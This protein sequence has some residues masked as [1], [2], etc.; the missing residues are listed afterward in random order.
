MWFRNGILTLLALNSLACMGQSSLSFKKVKL[1]ESDG[2][3]VLA[4]VDFLS[5]Q[6]LIAIRDAHQT[7]IDI[8]YDKIARMSYW[9]TEHSQTTKKIAAGI[10]TYGL[11]SLFVAPAVE[12]HLIINYGEQGSARQTELILND[13]DLETFVRIAHLET[14]KE[15]VIQGSAEPASAATPPAAGAPSPA[16]APAAAVSTPAPVQAPP[17]APPPPPNA[18]G[19]GTVTV[20]STPPGADILVNGAYSGSTPSTLKLDPGQYSISVEKQ[21]LAPWQRSVTVTDSSALILDAQL[22][23]TALPPSASVPPPAPPQAV[24]PAAV[25]APPGSASAAAPQPAGSAAPYLHPVKVGSQWGYVDPEG[26]FRY[27]PMADSAD[28]FAEGRALVGVIARH[29]TSS[30][31]F[32]GLDF[33]FAYKEY[34]YGWID[35]SGRILIPTQFSLGGTFS[36][37]LALAG[38]VTGSTRLSC[39]FPDGGIS[40]F[41]TPTPAD[42]AN[43]ATCTSDSKV[44]YVDISGNVALHTDFSDGQKFSEKLA[45]VAV[46]GAKPA[47]TRWG[48]IDHTGTLVIA[49]T[50]FQA[51]PF[52]EG[53]AGVKVKEGTKGKGEEWGF[54]DHTG[55][56]VVQPGYQF[57]ENFSEGM[58]AVEYPSGHGAG[59]VSREAHPLEKHWGYIDRSGAQ[60][61]PP[62]YVMAQPF[63]EGFAAVNTET[64]VVP[65]GDNPKRPRMVQHPQWSFIDRTGRI[66]IPGP[67]QATIRFSGGLAPAK[68]DDLWGY[69]DTSGA[70]R[71][72]PQFQDARIFRGD[73]A[74]VQLG[75][76]WGFI[77]RTGKFVVP[78][79]FDDV[80]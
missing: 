17:M 7:A 6:K 72:P 61:I 55:T 58:A 3:V 21:G 8:P 4:R 11:G 20:T 75:A 54:I 67:Y 50:F 25:P 39:S 53:L 56:L 32:A 60:V 69:I 12:Y 73:R 33:R 80:K 44:E 57:V 35:E 19:R 14:G 10:A 45:A 30:L 46:P 13:K 18:S 66:V 63:Y 36:E 27:A 40:V 5:D 9:R 64:M 31:P 74:A 71:I 42:N 68:K 62:S 2:R 26:K 16:S 70:F 34:N 65:E 23:A 24:P 41:N 22:A 49:A 51:Q 28:L 15:V 29:G 38:H 77:D 76:K 48:Y 1:V 43:E 59:K 79:Q 37:G 78:P 47:D 52:S